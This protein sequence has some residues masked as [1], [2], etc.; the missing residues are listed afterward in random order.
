MPA[1]IKELKY[2]ITSDCFRYTGSKSFQSFLKLYLQSPG[3]NYTFWIRIC[4]FIS[5]QGGGRF[6]N[7]LPRLILKHKSYKFGIDIPFSTSIDTGLYIGHFGGII[8]NGRTIIGKNCNLSQGVTIGSNTD[9]KAVIGDNV[10]IGPGA[11]I[12]GG[13]QIG[14][15]SEIGANA[16]VTHDVP[17][18]TCFAGVPARKIKDL[19]INPRYILHADY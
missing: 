4:S 19:D 10:Y 6:L 13:V 17:P 12:I 11:K 8:V 2:V 9:K 1:T 14:N 16:V 15:N 3:F 5:K 7:I 18:Y